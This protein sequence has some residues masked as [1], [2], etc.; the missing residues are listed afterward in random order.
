MSTNLSFINVLNFTKITPAIM[1]LFF[2]LH[3]SSV[4]T[5]TLLSPDG[6]DAGGMGGGAAGAATQAETGLSPRRGYG[7]LL[8]PA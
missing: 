6:E 4:I 7:E 2:F 8:L 5:K 3:L 1:D